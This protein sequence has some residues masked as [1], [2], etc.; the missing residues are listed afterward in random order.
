[1]IHISMIP[2]ELINK[3]NITDKVH[4]GYI[5]SQ[6]TKGVYGLP[7]AGRIAHGTLVQNLAPYQYHPLNKTPG[8]CTHK[9][10][11]INFTLV[12]DAFGVKYP[13]K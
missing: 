12:V 11:P 1:M 13:V 9:I 5:F 7:Q 6:V 10:C 4:N 8:L 3:Y 2:Q